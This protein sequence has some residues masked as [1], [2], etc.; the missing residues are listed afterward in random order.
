MNDAAKAIMTFNPKIRITVEGGGSGIG[1]QKVGEGLVAIGNT[2]RPLSE[3]EIAKYGLKSFP[4]ALDG[5]AVVIHPDNPISRL[6]SQQVRDIF[7]CV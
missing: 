2:G 5:V 4:F 6:T 3:A 1:V 7:K